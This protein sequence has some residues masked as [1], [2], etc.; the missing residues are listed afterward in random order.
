[1]VSTIVLLLSLTCGNTGAEIS[2]DHS[3]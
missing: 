2:K 3:E 1:M